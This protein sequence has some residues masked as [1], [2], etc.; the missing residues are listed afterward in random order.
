MDAIALLFLMYTPS[1]DT[2]AQPVTP[3]AERCDSRAAL[4]Y[5]ALAVFGFSFTMPA[6]RV[7]ALELDPWLVGFSRGALAGLLALLVLHVRREARPKLSQL[8]S[9]ALVALG[10]V[11]GFPLLTALA[12]RHVPAHHAVLV[13]GLTPLATSL[14]AALRNRERPSLGF[15]LFALTG[16][17][18]VVLFAANG[19]ALHFELAD[20]LLL[21]AVLLVSLG[22]AEGGRLAHELT[23]VGVIC[24]AL[25]LALPLTLLACALVLFR[26]GLP[27]PSLAALGCL[28]Y[29][30]WVS[31]LF[32]FVAWY[33]G[34]ALGGVARGSQVQLLQPILSLAWCALWLGEALQPSAYLTASLVL[35]SAAATRWLARA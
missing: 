2:L 7:A 23:G 24:W 17:S 13:I 34:L 12:L 27:S 21:G 29:I 5:C 10:V 8:R 19:R 35:A 31:T 9:L 11:L 3:S 30:A 32:A 25:V 28:G 16:A 18:A 33:R 22:Y 15:W 14:C 1:N 26:D 6:T 20:L 4:G